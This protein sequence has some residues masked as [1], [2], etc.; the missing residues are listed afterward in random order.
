MHRYQ[1]WNFPNCIGSIDG[2]HI[3][4]QKPKQSGSEFHNYKHTESI[5]LMA[6]CDAAYRFTMVDIGQSGSQSDGGVFES[7]VFGTA[8]L[9]GRMN[10]PEPEA[11]PGDPSGQPIP[12]MFVA[13]EAFPLRP[14][15][16][17]PFP[18]RQLDS[19]EKRIFNYRLSRARRV[20]ENTFGI[21]S[22]RWHLLFRPIIAEPPKVVL[23]VKAMC[24][25][26][27][28]MRA[29]ADQ[30]YT[31]PGFIDS[32]SPDG[33]INEGFWRESQL[34][35]LGQTGYHSRSAT[36]AANSIRDHLVEYFS[37]PQGSI[38]WQLSVV[39]AR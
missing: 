23:L 6:V 27:N 33:R 38:P 13:D 28:L 22:H 18:G 34:A 37:S 8:L 5:V 25:L 24:A 31:P 29:K 19:R 2:K 20:I 35:V 14:Y 30:Q 21:L 7:S 1:V 4:I 12:H 16:M 9:H 17:R 26:H 15:L 11:L 39:D 10:L 3:L 36:V 32:V